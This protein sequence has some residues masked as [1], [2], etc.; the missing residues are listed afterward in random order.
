MTIF[1]FRRI[2]QVSESWHSEGGLVI[3]AKN[4]DHARELAEDI[5]VVRL[6]IFQSVNDESLQFFEFHLVLI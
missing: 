5:D 6:D 2:D 3:V 4:A 1:V